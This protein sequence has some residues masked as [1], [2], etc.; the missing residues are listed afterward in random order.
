[1]PSDAPVIVV[2]DDSFEPE[3]L[4]SEVPVLVDFWAPW[5][6]PCRSM[7]P[8]LEALAQ[9]YQGR[10]KVV[11]YNTEAHQAVS[12][13]MKIRSLPTLVLFRSGE[14]IDARVGALTQARLEAW[15]KKRL[16]PQPGFLAR[17]IGRGSDSS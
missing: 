4:D 7:A 5:C 13:A 16:W 14:V 6:G 12:R 15:L 9:Q 10:L 17:L 11:K 3:V 1:M 2:N 8:A